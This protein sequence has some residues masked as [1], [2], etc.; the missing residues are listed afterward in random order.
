MKRER[1]TASWFCGA[2]P[3]GSPEDTQILA[4]VAK[5]EPGDQGLLGVSIQWV[6]LGAPRPIPGMRPK[7]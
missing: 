2:R 7:R 3:V 4:E 5:E 1:N 6:R